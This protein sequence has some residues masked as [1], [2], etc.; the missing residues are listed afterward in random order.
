MIFKSG[1]N[2]AGVRP[3]LTLG[4]LVADAVWRKHGQRLVI[5]S[6]ND[7]KHSL[8]SLH[9]AGQAG[10][11]RTRYFTPEEVPEVAAELREDMGHN[12]DYDVVVE[13]DHIHLEWQPKRKD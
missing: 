12:S 8:T 9:W 2:P 10:D 11:L 7:G 5:T 4:L 1:V 13:D 6:L 3:E